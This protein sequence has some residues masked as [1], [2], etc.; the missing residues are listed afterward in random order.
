MRLKYLGPRS[1]PEFAPEGFQF[2]F[3]AGVTH[4]PIELVAKPLWDFLQWT[5]QNPPKCEANNP[6]YQADWTGLCEKIDRLSNR[7]A[8]D[9][10]A[11]IAH[12]LL[13]RVQKSF[14]AV[15]QSKLTTLQ[16]AKDGP[17]VATNPLAVAMFGGLRPD[18]ADQDIITLRDV[19]I[20]QSGRSDEDILIE[21]C[22]GR[23]HRAIGTR[24]HDDGYDLADQFLNELYDI[25]PDLSLGDF[26]DIYKICGVLGIDI[27]TRI[28]NTDSIRGV[29]LAGKGFGPTILVNENFRFNENDA[30]RRFTVAHELCHILVDRNRACEIGH[31]SGPWALPSIEKRANAF[32]AYVLMPRE[33]VLSEIG[34]AN[35]I[36]EEQV[37]RLADKLRVSFIAL[38]QHLYN[39]GVLDDLV[40]DELLSVS[41]MHST[42]HRRTHRIK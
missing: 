26:V 12:E 19:L 33:L 1:R 24:P 39:L 30:G 29:A 22:D 34:Q 21:L 15:G 6:N 23:F 41:A 27:D 42:D 4:L 20:A 14:A 10:A 25:K 8:Q 7:P 9:M 31:S 2:Q 36:G 35:N 17:Y 3:A 40:R 5:T 38:T 16:R 32:A 13:L 28:L 37:R 11:D 18:L